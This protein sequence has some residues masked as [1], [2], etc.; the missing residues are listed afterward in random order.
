MVFA[1]IA[2]DHK[3]LSGL[4]VA[5][6]G[7]DDIELLIDKNDARVAQPAAGYGQGKLIVS[8]TAVADIG[9]D[10][11]I[12]VYIISAFRVEFDRDVVLIDIG[13]YILIGE[14]I[15]VHY[16]TPAAPIGIK[17]DQD[18]FLLGLR[19]VYR[20]LDGVPPDLLSGFLVDPDSTLCPNVL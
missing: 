10:L 16:L 5:L 18:L 6:D 4:L 2:N 8:F 20:L 11:V 14:G 13:D 7:L 17:I 1:E 12:E 19:K 15:F 3:E 9:I